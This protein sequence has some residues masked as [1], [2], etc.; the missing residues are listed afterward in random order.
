M[1]RDQMR[2]HDAGWT[3][4]LTGSV[5]AVYTRSAMH[6]SSYMA[7]KSLSDDDVARA[8]ARSRVSVSRYRRRLVR[9]DFE[10]IQRIRTFTKGRV[11]EADWRLLAADRKS[12]ARATRVA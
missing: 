5:H 7:E 9:P 10:T 6:L 12:E 2:V 4:A 11:T 8:I 3:K 1:H